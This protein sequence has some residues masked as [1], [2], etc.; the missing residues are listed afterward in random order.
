MT[1][2][3]LCLIMQ[4]CLAFGLTG[5]VRP[6]KLMSLFAILM[7]PWRATHNV[8]RANGVLIVGAY[9]AVLAKIVGTGI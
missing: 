1:L 7:F 5:L 9:L 6:E 8:I 3:V 2:L 4:V